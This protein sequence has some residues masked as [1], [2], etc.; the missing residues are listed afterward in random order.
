MVAV[1][2]PSRPP[3]IPLTEGAEPYQGNI[4]QLPGATGMPLVAAWRGEEA[5]G[6]SRSSSGRDRI[7]YRSQTGN[8]GIFSGAHN[9]SIGQMNAAETQSIG[10][11]GVGTQNVA[12]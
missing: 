8:G 2:T 6:H 12:A 1:T 5:H 10:T 4:G 11:Q 7:S 3:D 9:F